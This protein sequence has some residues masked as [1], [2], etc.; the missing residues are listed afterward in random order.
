MAT[1]VV[2]SEST[3]TEAP[4]PSASNRSEEVV[5]QKS[6]QPVDPPMLVTFDRWFAAKKY[7]PHWKDGMLAFTNT[8]GR[9]TMEEWDS[10]FKKY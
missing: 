4:A 8:D 10:I 3:T 2:R 1:K 7:K 6:S 5:A 9:K